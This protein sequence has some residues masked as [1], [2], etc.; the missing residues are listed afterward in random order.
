MSARVR[1]AAAAVLAFAVAFLVVGVAAGGDS[2][3]Q[4]APEVAKLRLSSTAD[5]PSLAEDPAVVARRRA[6]ARRAARRARALRARRR[7]ERRAAA[8]E[9][10]VTAP[11]PAAPEPAPAPE[12]AAG[13]GPGA[14]ARAGAA[15]T[16]ATR[17]LRRRGMKLLTKRPQ[18]LVLDEGAVLDGYRVE[19]SDDTHVGP[20]LR[21]VVSGPGGERALLLMSRHP[22][23]DRQERARF[24]RLAELRTR[25]A[26]PAAIEVRD[27]GEHARTSVPRDGAA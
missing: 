8:T 21:Y 12:P 17:D 26:H 24:R 22:F 6:R 9:A 15:S 5:L 14:R 4:A 7:A 23:A 16:A 2:P 25:F 13:S 19:E 1:I 11:A 3:P 20:E 18:A 27:F 10:V